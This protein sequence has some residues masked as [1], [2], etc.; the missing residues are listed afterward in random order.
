MASDFTKEVRDLWREADEADR[1]NRE[2]ALEDLRFA[3]GE[4]WDQ[5][6]RDYRENSGPFPLPC[7]T[8]NTLPQFIGQVIGDRRANQTSIKV[9][10]NDDGDV[11]IA[12]V[13]SEVFRSIEL[14]SKAERVYTNAFDNAVTCGIGNFRIDIDY[15]RDDAF[16]RDIF[17]NP[18]PNPFAVRWDPL[19]FD[20][21]GRDAGWCFVG[22]VLSDRAYEKQYPKAAKPSLFDEEL[23]GIGWKTAGAV[24]VPEYWRIEEETRTIAMTATGETVD[25]TD[26]P[27]AK[28]P[29]LLIDPQTNE[30][31]IRDD[32]KCKYA[33]MV[34][35]NGM[36]ELSDPLKLKIP[37]LP[38]IRVQGREIWTGE[39]RVRFGITRFARDP[40]RLK[41]YWR[42]VI[43]ELLMSAPRDNYVAEADSI[44][45]R[46]K[47]WPNTRIYNTGTKAP[48]AVTLADL[49]ALVNEAQLCAQDM[50]DVTGLHDASLGERSNETSGVA[51]QQRQHEG[52]IAT[53]IFHDNMNASM[54]EAGEVVDALF[55][56][57]YDTARTLRAV[58]VDGSVKMHRINDPGHPDYVDI[59]VGRYDVTISTGPAYMTRRQ[60]NAASM[61]NAV[62]SGPAGQELLGVAGDLIVKSQDWDNAD[63]IAARIRRKM[64]PSLLTAS[65]RKAMKEEL[66]NDAEDPQQQEAQQ[67]QQQMQQMGVELEMQAK[68]ADA[69]LKGAQADRAEAEA[70]KA[71]AETMR[72]LG[73]DVDTS[74]TDNDSVRLAIE[75]FN[76][77][78]NRI[79]A[80]SSTA[81]PGA[82]PDLAAHIGP[83]V[84][85]AIAQALA[86]HAQFAPA[87]VG[88]IPTEEGIA[89]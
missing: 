69:R 22:D 65:E 25:L 63:E 67:Q 28:W 80:L 72:L 44:K 51:I 32:A 37:R 35:T 54:Q 31:V 7:L 47:D 36:E 17:I 34:K 70:L 30:P 9:L 8:I 49:A 16:E 11:K 71:K 50:K 43:A 81:G 42:S 10:P 1:E 4:Q 83:I 33:I 5:R 21:T 23:I 45:S 2:E 60:E 66:G 76:A 62:N 52:D 14:R 46:E 20:P 78:T 88:A 39:K 73:G 89:Q 24:M 57:V 15:A 38:I 53:I 48:E 86:K 26:T 3:A 64:D 85:E 13:R 19:A 74:Q 6:V 18:I 55:P 79:K 29:E 59:G 75:G 77:E 40:Q 27:K 12:Q 82:P 56:T 84:S 87:G 61:M 58:G 41:N 68:Q